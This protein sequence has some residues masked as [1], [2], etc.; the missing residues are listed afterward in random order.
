MHNSCQIN[1][2]NVVN[3][4]ILCLQMKKYSDETDELQ[5]FLLYLIKSLVSLFRNVPCTSNQLDYTLEV[6]IVIIKIQWTY[7]YVIYLLGISVIGRTLGSHTLFTR[8]IRLVDVKTAIP[9]LLDVIKN[10]ASTTLV[11][12]A[13]LKKKKMCS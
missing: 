6:T 5:I 10:F 4:T 9:V 3:Y 12:L 8:N 11:S 7:K 1:Y 13:A 2:N